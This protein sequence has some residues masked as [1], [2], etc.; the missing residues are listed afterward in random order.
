MSAYHR[1]LSALD[2]AVALCEEIESKTT[3]A[4]VTML[5][6]RLKAALE[7]VQKTAEDWRYNDWLS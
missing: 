2:E 5:C 7:K 6:R 1:L 3:S 4:R